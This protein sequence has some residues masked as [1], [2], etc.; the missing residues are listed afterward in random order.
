MRAVV[1]LFD[2]FTFVRSQIFKCS[3]QKLLSNS[4]ELQVVNKMFVICIF[5][6]CLRV[7][8]FIMPVSLGQ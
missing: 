6:I 2:F 3:P 1:L 5:M 8:V 7:V 4:E